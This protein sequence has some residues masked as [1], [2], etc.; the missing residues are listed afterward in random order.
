METRDEIEVSAALIRGES[1]EKIAQRLARQGVPQDEIERLFAQNADLL[2]ARKNRSQARKTAR[3]VGAILF[4][5]SLAWNLYYIFYWPSGRIV[6]GLF[7]AI[8][9]YGL[10][11]MIL[12]DFCGGLFSAM[13]RMQDKSNVRGEPRR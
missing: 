12:G 13:G 9:F 7:W 4:A 3:V 11:V 2:S 10:M 8:T 5:L 1:P 6:F